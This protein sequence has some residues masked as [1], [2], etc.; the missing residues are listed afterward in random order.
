MTQPERAGPRS[1]DCSD[2]DTYFESHTPVAGFDAPTTRFMHFLWA[3]EKLVEDGW[4]DRCLCPTLLAP[5]CFTI[6]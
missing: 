2:L 5:C 4:C 3:D 1:R 6:D